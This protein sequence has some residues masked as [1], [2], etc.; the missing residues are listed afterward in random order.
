MPRPTSTPRTDRVSGQATSDN[1]RFQILGPLRFWRDGI[2]VNPG[3]QQQRLLLALLLARAGRPISTDSLIE[4][5]WG[6]GAPAAA[7]NVIHKYVGALR[8]LMEPTLSVRQTGSYLR[9]H[10]NGYLLTA[11]TGMVDL[12]TF[13]ELAG[14]A[15]ASLAEERREEAL[16]LYV[17]ALC[18]WRGS[19]SDALAYGPA[20]TSIFAAL[21]EE[22]LDV[23]GVAADLAVT[24]GQPAR[25]LPP[26][27][28]AASI[29]PLNEQVQAS[30]I[31]T[32]AAA[33]QQAEALSVFETVRARL[34]E[35][36]GLDPGECLQRVQR[37]VLGQ[38]VTPAVTA[39]VTGVAPADTAAG[40]PAPLT[41][42]AQLPPDLPIFV[43]RTEELAT[44]NEW[45]T[46]C[47]SARTGPLVVALDGMGGVGK[48]TLA[49][50]FAHRVAPEFVDG[51]FCLDLRGH[52]AED[53]AMSAGEALRSLL[54]SQGVRVSSMPET[55]EALVGTWRSLTAGQRILILLD[56]VQDFTQVRPLLPNS[57]ESLVLVTSRKPL[58]GLAALDGA[59][60]LHLDPPDMPTARAL[61]RRRIERMPGRSA[62]DVAA[63]GDALDEI[64]ELCGRLPLALAILGGRLSA[65][66]RLSLAA[67]ASE[68]RDGTQRLASFPGGRG[69]RDPRA[70]FGWSYRQL[71]P[72][73]ARLFRLFSAA[74]SPGITAEACASLAGTPPL[75]VRA[76]LAELADAALLDEDDRGR[77][78]SHVL[79]KA[80]AQELFL[81]E[82]S[83]ADRR[84]AVTRL[85][86]HYL[87]SS[88]HAMAVL[89]PKGSLAAPPPAGVGVVPER[90]GTF[91][92]AV[93]WFDDNHEMLH[94]AVRVAGDLDSAIVPWQLALSMQSWLQR[95]GRFHDWQ[96]VMRLSLRSARRTGDRV[97]E[98]HALRSLGC[99]RHFFGAHQEARELLSDALKIFVDNDMPLEQA[100]VHLNLHRTYGEL[101][102]HESAIEHSE[103][104][105]ALY[106]TVG[107]EDAEIWTAEAR[108][109]SLVLLGDTDQ[110]RECLEKALV[111][112]EKTGRTTDEPE[113]RM[114]LARYFVE[115][116][117]PDDAVGQLDQAVRV[118]AETRN[119]IDVFQAEILLHDTRLSLDDEAGARRA[120]RNAHDTMDAMQN[121]GTP[122]MRETITGRAGH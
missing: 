76:L 87:H 73:A 79:V 57:A 62:A 120:W 118:A 66:P 107:V 106:R 37:Q 102:Q 92:E 83:E 61:L 3:P 112:A 54:S 111:L 59:Y 42:P 67:L 77:F 90:P 117:R 52:D 40:T 71:S 115:I 17:D 65:R 43:G 88:L 1:L 36:L 22:L 34:A 86:Q 108:G 14:A 31:Y 100:V 70:A 18:L 121:G 89:R 39:G 29:A 99:A 68:L 81:A 122:S 94:E 51:Q 12:L 30:R 78:T 9:R 84:A 75:V 5:I 109:R 23:C 24:L 95:S 69:V 114:S 103:R 49:T 16:D 41:R 35:D 82:E 60:L 50:H 33:G 47:D 6:N 116:G 48:S 110:A 26:L 11:G 20:A 113:I 45:L 27:R 28:L 46:T 7:R 55:L 15:R 101:G 105:R 8:R 44:L 19:S 4:L 10:G 13:R 74:L 53:A 38:T 2:E 91:D 32:L 85:L 63:P 97:G 93:R 80:Y 21:D 104:A 58:V 72:D 119:R 25:V 98:A 56:N 96:D 64:I